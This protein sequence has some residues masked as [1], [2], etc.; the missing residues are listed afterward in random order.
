MATR[1]WTGQGINRAQVNRLA[2][3][4]ISSGSGSFTVTIN[5]NT[6]VFNSTSADSLA[7]VCAGIVDAVNSADAPEFGEVSAT[8]DDTYV[9]LTANTPGTP[10]TSTSSATGT[11]AALTTSTTTA[12]KSRND[13]SD[14]LNWAGGTVP[15]DTDD[16][17]VENTDQSIL[18]GLDQSS[19]NLVTLTIRETFTG[20][21]GLPNINPNGYYEYRSTVLTFAEVATLTITHNS[22]DPAQRFRITVGDN[23]CDLIVN[24]PVD[25]AP[26]TYGVV[27]WDAGT[28]THTVAVNNGSVAIAPDTQDSVTV[29]TLKAVDSA[30][31][32]GPNATVTTA[33]LDGQSSAIFGKSPAT[34]TLNGGSYA[35][36]Q[37]GAATT[38]TITRG[39][40]VWQGGNI[41]TLTVSPT[42]SISFDEDKAAIT[43]TNTTLH[44][45]GTLLD[46]NK[47]VTY[48]NGIDL[49]ECGIEE[50]TLQLGKHFTV[51]PSAI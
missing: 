8:T 1:I 5:N 40:V 6:A 3:T 18:Y 22:G 42:S 21:I 9:Y 15:V 34:L 20:T 4:V 7:V 46:G 33:T 41:T 31:N 45:N 11:S 35:Q 32:T 30:V 51:T 27:E 28:G 48:T 17:I 16:V 47:R 19:I 36:I 2:P 25:S 10:F 29:S 24:G 44:Y 49:Y 12:N 14:T 50:V 13:W 38:L 23:D 43:V 37:S 26:S 39:Q